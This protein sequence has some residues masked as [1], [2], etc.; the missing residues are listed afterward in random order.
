MQAFLNKL[1]T[2]ACVIINYVLFSIFFEVKVLLA[3]YSF[4]LILNYFQRVTNISLGVINTFLND[5]VISNS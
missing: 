3:K 1:R 5:L 2:V 4:F